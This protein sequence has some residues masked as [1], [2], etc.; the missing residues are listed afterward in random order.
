M[1]LTVPKAARAALAL[2][3]AGSIPCFCLG[4]NGSGSTWNRRRDCAT[5]GKYAT[6][7]YP[8]PFIGLIMIATTVMSLRRGGLVGYDVAFTRLRPR[9][10]LS[11]LV[12]RYTFANNHKK[13]PVPN[14]GR[15]VSVASR[16]S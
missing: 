9:V 14:S 5:A 6:G 12:E 8:L 11:L 16:F 7:T 15:A 10:Q 1:R 4:G 2:C 3:V 13:S